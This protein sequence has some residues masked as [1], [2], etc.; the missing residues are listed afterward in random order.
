MRKR[1]IIE[2]AL[3]TALALGST[4][5]CG[6]ENVDYSMENEDY[7]MA[8]KLGVPDSVDTSIDTG[9]SGLNSISIKT[10]DIELPDATNMSVV[11]FD[12]LKMTEE[13]RQTI[14]EYLLNKDDGIGIYDESLR[15]VGDLQM[16]IDFL[17]AYYTSEESVADLKEKMESAPDSYSQ[18]DSFTYDYYTGVVDGVRR[19][20]KME[21]EDTC[22]YLM[23]GNYYAGL[24]AYRTHDGA[25]F[26]EFSAAESTE[27]FTGNNTC[28]ITQTAAAD[29]AE[30]LL[31]ELGL[32]GLMVCSSNVVKWSYYDSSLN[33]ITEEYDGYSFSYSREIDGISIYDEAIFNV[34][35]IQG[36]GY[37][38]ILPDDYLIVS[39]DGNGILYANWGIF[40]SLTGEE[41]T[42]VSLLSWDDLIEEVSDNLAAYYEKY[43]TSYTD[44][45]YDKVELTYFPVPDGDGGKYVPAWI[46][47]QSEG[48]TD[49]DDATDIIQIAVVNATN[50]EIIDIPEMLRNFREI[51]EGN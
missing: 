20:L 16:E 24:N 6:K 29:K 43:P 28:T 46:F 42:N 37:D 27:D 18:A 48:D 31:D 30:E 7:T 36:D 51:L 11:Y 4:G 39:V 34:E 8:T 26:A 5:G 49:S 17:E 15:T 32:T 38:A 22:E 2:A 41:E 44:I 13:Y 25:T 35:N 3:I 40:S 50:G 19:I 33:L 10:D 12:K 14:A 47:T 21:S 45:C 9:E 23:Y 1:K